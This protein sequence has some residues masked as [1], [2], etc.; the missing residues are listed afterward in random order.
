MT[1]PAVFSSWKEIAQ[2]F[3]KSVRTVQRWER[4]LDLPVIRPENTSG[5]IVMAKVSDLEAW[6]QQP[7]ER[8]VSVRASEVT[9]NWAKSRYECRKRVAKMELLLADLN[10]HTQRLRVNTTAMS[11]SCMR[12]KAL[13]SKAELDETSS[14]PD[15]GDVLGDVLQLG[16][17]VEVVALSTK[18]PNP[19]QLSR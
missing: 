3:G 7:A 18:A 9:Q 11:L 17:A 15:A 13:S 4:T 8:D 1:T 2:Y 6:L 5:N 14:N 10:R 12:I 16:N 19:G